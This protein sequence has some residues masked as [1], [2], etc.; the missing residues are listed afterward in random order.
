M[1][2]HKDLDV[3][4]RSVDLV[5]EIY[6]IT[7]ESPSEEKFSLV[8]QPVDLLYQ[9]LPILQKVQHEIIIKN[10]FNFYMLPQEV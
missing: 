7:F 2:S 4:K 8:N 6:R 1:K 10:S 5:T 3:W 9:F